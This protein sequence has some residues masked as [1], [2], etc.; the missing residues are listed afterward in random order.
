MHT[1]EGKLSAEGHKVGI[2][3]GRFNSSVSKKLLEGALDCLKR[4][5]CSEDSIDVVWV[6]GAFEIPLT[7]Q[8][9]A[10]TGQ[11]DSIICLGAVIRGQTPHFDYVSSQVSSGITRTMLDTG[12]PIIFGVLTT[13]TVDEAVE[14]SGLKSGNK[15][16]DAALAAIEMGNILRK[17]E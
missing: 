16:W 15:G 2:V 9:M 10:Q 5:S 11:Y 6:P 17:F 13:N 12:V 3:V 14:R 4:H 8:K 1:I 7:T